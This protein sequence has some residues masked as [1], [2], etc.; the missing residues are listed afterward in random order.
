MKFKTRATAGLLLLSLSNSSFAVAP[1]CPDRPTP[2]PCCAD[3]RCYPNPLTFGVY[4][5]RW[6]RWPLEVAA[7]APENQP[8]A[9]VPPAGDVPRFET[10]PAEEEDQKAPPPTEPR[11]EPLPNVPVNAAP[12]SPTG[13]GGPTQPGGPSTPPQTVP[14]MQPPP[15]APGGTPTTPLGPPRS[16]PRYEPQTPSTRPPS[17]LVPN[18]PTSE[19]DPPPSLPFGPP[20]INAAMP[21]HEALEG[22]MIQT[23]HTAPP[24]ARSTD[25][26]P[27]SLP[28]ALMSYA[29]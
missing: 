1:P 21:G 19:S 23:P 4:E 10:P 11:A 14:M 3:G 8:G 22:P 7:L 17:R 28:V 2:P 9:A 29:K 24:A 13:P 5:T 6:R 20:T 25:D 16:L 15:A 26:P 27:P 18:G 12:G